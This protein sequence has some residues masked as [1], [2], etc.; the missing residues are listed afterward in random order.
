MHKCNFHFHVEK[1][2]RASSAKRKIVQDTSV[3]TNNTN[4]G[5]LQAGLPSSALPSSALPS[6]ELIE[7]KVSRADFFTKPTENIKKGQNFNQDVVA[8]IPKRLTDKR[9]L[10]IVKIAEFLGMDDSTGGYRTL[11]PEKK[12]TFFNEI[13][14]HQR[15]ASELLPNTFSSTVFLTTFETLN[16]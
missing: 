14:L 4:C 11:M 10:E 1:T 16:K 9:R 8:D 5:S 15:A 7:K 12:N 6:S 13:C 3:I 2:I